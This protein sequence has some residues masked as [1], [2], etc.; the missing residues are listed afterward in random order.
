[1][2]IQED[3]IWFYFTE[4]ELILIILITDLIINIWSANFQTFAFP[5][6]A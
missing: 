2:N 5:G 3:S 4:S 1:M 6:V